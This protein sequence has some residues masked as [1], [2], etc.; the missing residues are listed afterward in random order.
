MGKAMW[1]TFETID[2]PLKWL[3]SSSFES[4]WRD[5]KEIMA[6]KTE[7]HYLM[8]TD[9]ASSLKTSSHLVGFSLLC[10]VRPDHSS[11]LTSSLFVAQQDG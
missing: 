6:T 10:Q 11:T 2:Q 5:S 1:A 3:R 8:P 9:C 4:A 7:N